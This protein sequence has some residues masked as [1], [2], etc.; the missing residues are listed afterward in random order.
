MR[1]FRRLSLRGRLILIGATG[2]AVGLLI[3]GLVLFGVLNYVLNQSLDSGA[4]KTASDLAD[5]INANN[6]VMDPAPPAGSQFVQ[7]VNEQ[8][9][10]LTAS[11]GTDRMHSILHADELDR[12]RKGQ[13]VVIGGDRVG[14]EG[15]LRVVAEATFQT[16]V[17]IVVVGAPERDTRQSLTSVAHA[18]LVAYPLLLIMLTALAWWV[19][20]RTLRPVEGLRRGAEEISAAQV[21]RLPVPVGEDEVHRLAVTLNRMLDRL[22]AA[23]SRQRA[24]VADAAHEL[25]SPI[26]SL[27]TQLDVATHLGEPPVIADLSMEVDR[28]N[29]LVSDLLLLARVDEG[30]PGLRRQEPVDLG[31]LL[32]EVAAGCAGARVPVTATSDGPQWTTGDAA[33]L[34]RVVDN[35][36]ANAVRHAHSAVRLAVGRSADRVVFT[37]TDDGPGIPAADRDRVFD[38]F[39]RLDDARAR[40]AG[41]TGL[42]LAIVRELVRAH[43]GTVTLGDAAPGLRVA[44]ALPAGDPATDPVSPSVASP[45]A[46][47]GR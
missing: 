26:A 16:P 40:D 37:V 8:G 23:R 7:V 39:T 24:F 3:G 25:R 19:V 47:R 38:R 2:L 31:R 22:D 46:P 45:S 11:P 21:G 29:R 27:R 42:G 15:N 9:Q 17:S 18:L 10:V 36:V 6:S 32:A 12:A 35:L 4:R 13:V 5:L 14:I 20:G 41:G 30:D 44:V 1:W 34:H 43:G 28:L 33:A